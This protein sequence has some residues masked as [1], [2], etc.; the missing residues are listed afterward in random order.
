MALFPRPAY[1]VCCNYFGLIGLSL[2]VFLKV[3]MLRYPPHTNSD[4]GK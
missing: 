2:P 1:D 3:Q 4:I